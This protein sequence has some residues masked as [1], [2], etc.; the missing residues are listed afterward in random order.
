MRP[1]GPTGRDSFCSSPALSCAGRLKPV[2]SGPDHSQHKR[3]IPLSVDGCE[4]EFL[5][6]LTRV[7][8]GDLN[9]SVLCQHSSMSQRHHQTVHTK[10]KPSTFKYYSDKQ[11]HFT[12]VSVLYSFALFFLLFP[13]T[14]YCS[15]DLL[16]FS[17]GRVIKN[18][19][20]WLR[21]SAY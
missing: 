11:H 13:Q 18:P 7:L 12:K 4:P 14:V 2:H 19:I 6:T 17:I 16:T 5:L 15:D 1:H 3:V 9:S 20:G 21:V 8:E 10:Y